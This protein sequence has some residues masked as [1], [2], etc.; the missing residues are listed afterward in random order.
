MIAALFVLLSVPG[1]I[2]SLIGLGSRPRRLAGWG[3]GLGIFC[4]MY[5]GTLLFFIV[6]VLQSALR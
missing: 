1:L 2:L 5:L 4:C 6:H 3:V